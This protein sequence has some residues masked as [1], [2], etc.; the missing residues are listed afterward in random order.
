MKEVIFSIVTFAIHLT[1]GIKDRE[2]SPNM[3]RSEKK[4]L[5]EVKLRNKNRPESSSIEKLKI[6]NQY[7]SSVSK[8]SYEKEDS[9]SDEEIANDP[10]ED[11]DD[12]DGTDNV[13]KVQKEG[14]NSD[15]GIGARISDIKK[16]LNQVDDED[17][18]DEDEQSDELLET[19]P[20]IPQNLVTKAANADLIDIVEN[21]GGEGTVK[22]VDSDEFDEVEI[23]FEGDEA[24]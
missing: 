8:K 6:R 2:T 10:D 14:G 17:S 15:F 4:D 3:N 5:E 19:S 12:Y 1:L 7:K 18:K 16:A 20:I 24:P 11:D 9:Y 23:Q 13:D 22:D 21:Q